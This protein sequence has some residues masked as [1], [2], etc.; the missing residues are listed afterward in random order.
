MS[1]LI[2]TIFSLISDQSRFGYKHLLQSVWQQFRAYGLVARTDFG[3]SAAAFCKA[4][5]KLPAD[6]IKHIFYRTVDYLQKHKPYILWKN[7]RLFAIDA[8]RVRLPHSDELVA[9]FKCPENQNGQ[10]HY[11]QALISKCY[12]I[13]SDVPYDFAVAG[14]D[15]SERELAISHL[16]RLKPGDV[17]IGDRGY[18]GFIMFWQLLKHGLHFIFRAPLNRWSVI[19]RFLRSGKKEQIVNFSMTAKVKKQYKADATVPRKLRLRLIRITLPTGETEV[20]ITS[21]VDQKKYSYEHFNMLYQWR[22]PVEESMKSMKSH[23]MIENFHAKDING[24]LQEINAHFLLMALTRLI[25]W[26]A[27]AEKPEKFYGLSYKAAVHFF[28]LQSACLLMVK[29]DKLLARTLTEL[30]NMITRMYERTRP[31][32]SNPR[33]VRA[34]KVNHFPLAICRAP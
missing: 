11:P 30:I 2:F 29:N 5:K 13:F 25:M 17:V 22:W 18:P 7:H 9:Y 3:P 20:L 27:T 8:M 1:T 6:V 23:H 14:Y 21:L 12:H 31:N 33:Q 10:S 26:Q 15:A 16:D 19:K 34:R 32:R 28:F 4:R 24:I